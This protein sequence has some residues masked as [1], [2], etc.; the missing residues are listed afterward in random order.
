MKLT[1]DHLHGL[2]EM[3]SQTRDHELTCD[4]CLDQ[5]AQLAEREMAGK[6][7]DAALHAARQHLDICPEC[8]EE[9]ALLVD[10]LEA[11]EG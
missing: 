3:I 10:A 2:L 7:L 4:D 8:A 9:H 5:L 1:R 11:L 6:P